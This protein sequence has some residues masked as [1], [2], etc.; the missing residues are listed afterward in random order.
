MLRAQQYH[1]RGARLTAHSLLWCRCGVLTLL[2]CTDGITASP[3]RVLSLLPQD[4]TTISPSGDTS[5][6]SLPL[7]DSLALKVD[8]LDQDS[9]LATNVGVRWSTSDPSIVGITQNGDGSRSA[10]LSATIHAVGLGQAHISVDLVSGVGAALPQ[11]WTYVI[12]VKQRWFAV[13]SGERHTCAIAVNSKAYCWGAPGGLLGTGSASGSMVPVQ[14]K[15]LDGLTLERVSA[16]GEVSCALEKG[17]ILYCWGRNTYGEVGNGSLNPQLVAGVGGAGATY[18]DVSVGRRHTCALDLYQPYLRAFCWGEVNFGQIGSYFIHD[19]VP[20]EFLQ[21][22][23]LVYAYRS[24]QPIRGLPVQL[25]N[26]ALVPGWLSSGTTHSCAIHHGGSVSCWGTATVGQLG[27]DTTN[28]YPLDYCKAEQFGV[29][30]LLNLPCR[31]NPM[32]SPLGSFTA[33]SAGWDS[34]FAA[35][36]CAVATDSLAYCWGSNA[37][38]QLGTATVD[39]T[40]CRWDTDSVLGIANPRNSVPCSRTPQPIDGA[41]RFISIGAGAHHT[42]GLGGADSLVYCW[43]DN[44]FGQLGDGA[45][46]RRFTPQVAPVAVE[47]RMAILSVGAYHSCAIREVDGSLWCWGRGVDGELGNGGV[48]NSPV[49]IRVSEPR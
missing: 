1:Q 28:D 35:H 23:Q 33:V 29:F 43:G 6:S 49:G 46:Q 15:G 16:G 30:E 14:V 44:S 48:Q 8:V 20:C 45:F 36:T 39:P 42:C 37:Q 5:S 34:S 4:G 17:G 19:S 3:D 21:D 31:R 22:P 38:G 24:C 2:A 12:D 40:P 11:G 27:D 25:G 13:S 47:A 41:R 32:G 10:S 18:A 9:N 7:G 26:G